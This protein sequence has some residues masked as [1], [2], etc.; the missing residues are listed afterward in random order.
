MIIET[1]FRNWTNN[2]RV[3]KNKIKLV[4]INWNRKSNNKKMKQTNK[5]RKSDIYKYKIIE[6]QG[7]IGRM[8]K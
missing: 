7:K 3:K 2:M 1:K 8:L 4:K 6:F 5:M